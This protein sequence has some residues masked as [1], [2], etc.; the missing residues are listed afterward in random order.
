[1]SRTRRVSHVGRRV[2]QT[3]RCFD[4]PLEILST[5]A[6]ETIR[7]R[8]RDL[9]FRSGGVSVA[10][11]LTPGAVFPV[12]EV[13]AEDTYRLAQP[14]DGLRPGAHFLDVGAHLGS[15]SLAVAARC[16]GAQVHAYEASP[17]TSDYLARN[18]AA[19][20]LEQRVTCHPQAVSGRSSVID[21]SDDGSR[22]SM[23]S[24]TWRIEGRTTQVTSVTLA[25]AFERLDNVVDVVKIDAEGAEYDMVS[26][27]HTDL[28]STAQRVVLEYHQSPGHDA[29]ELVEFFAAAGLEVTARLPT[30]GNPHE[31]LLWLSR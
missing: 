24:L 13:F 14:T 22:S 10:A 4:N 2:V 6:R 28:W 30:P 29:H 19:S 25:T 20:G 18:I 31:G 16:P 17:T 1:M 27:T 12:Y 15:F 9:V 8:Q 11:P 23:N 5:V 7:P 26:A 21:F 3:A